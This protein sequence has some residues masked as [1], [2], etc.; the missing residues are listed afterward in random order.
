[1]TAYVNKAT[2]AGVKAFYE[3]YCP[4]PRPRR[5][6]VHRLLENRQSDFPAKVMELLPIHDRVWASASCFSFYEACNAL[7]LEFENAQGVKKFL[8]AYEFPR[9]SRIHNRFGKTPALVFNE[10]DAVDVVK[11]IQLL[12]RGSDGEDDDPDD[13]SDCFAA[14]K[15]ISLYKVTGLS[16]D[17]GK[18]FEQLLQTLFMDHVSSRLQILELIGKVLCISS[19]ELLILSQ[20]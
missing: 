20:T 6:L 7:P 9:T 4:P 5:Y 8:V 13:D 12:E 19:L 2:A 3:L 1:M 15:Q 14:V 17:R 16:A 18:S 11:V 10:A